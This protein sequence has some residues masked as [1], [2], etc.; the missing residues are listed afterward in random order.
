[1]PRSISKRRLKTFCTIEKAWKISLLM[2]QKLNLS[3]TKFYFIAFL[4]LFFNIILYFIQ[5]NVHFLDFLPSI[6]NNKNKLMQFKTQSLQ[7]ALP[8][9]IY[10]IKSIKITIPNASCRKYLYSLFK[11]LFSPCKVKNDCWM[12]IS[13][14]LYKS[15]SV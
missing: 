14:K 12:N 13:Y 5:F 10:F 1:M 9:T 15:F 4:N 3:Y 2:C 7:K 6:S 8:H 11:S